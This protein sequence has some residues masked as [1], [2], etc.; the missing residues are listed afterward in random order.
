MVDLGNQFHRYLGEALTENKELCLL[1]LGLLPCC[2]R[3]YSC[4][5]FWVIPRW[6]APVLTV[7]ESLLSSPGPP[8]TVNTGRPRDFTTAGSGDFPKPA[9]SCNKKGAMGWE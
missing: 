4:W 5:L 2:C 6:R 3:M 9:P 1:G 8:S 7:W